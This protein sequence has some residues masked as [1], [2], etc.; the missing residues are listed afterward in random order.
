LGLHRWG[1]HLHSRQLLLRERHHPTQPTTTT[2][3]TTSTG[4]TLLRLQRR[5]VLL[6]LWPHL[7]RPLLLALP[8]ALL[9]G[10]QRLRASAARHG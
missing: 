5:R 2:T 4:A 9:R 1:I 3:T 10:H 8:R 6:G 7:P